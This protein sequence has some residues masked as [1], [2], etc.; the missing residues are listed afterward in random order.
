MRTLIAER[1]VAPW[2][3]RL[4]LP[5]YKVADAAR[6]AD[7]SAQTI[8]N[9]Q[10]STDFHRPAIGERESGEAL[11][12]L[13]LVEV[14]FVAAM[15]RAGVKLQEIKNAREYLALQLQSEYPF[16]EKSFKTDGKDIWMSLDNLV[17][18]E[19]K[20]KLVKV[21]KGGQIAWAEIVETKFTEFEYEGDLAIR[22]HVAGPRSPVVID[23][24]V[25]FGAPMVKG[26]ATW[27]I[28]GR[29]AAGESLQDIAEDFSLQSDQVAEALK[30]EGIDLS[31]LKAWH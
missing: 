13:Q 10:V 12:Y 9:W 22:W 11:S 8:R 20:A 5:A 27:A 23:P 21:N 16:A 17:A 2:K 18:G 19:S 6:Y 15:R 3:R 7:I 30:F 29:W 25:S 24:R 4:F 14:A 28:K 1:G 31:Q 26:I